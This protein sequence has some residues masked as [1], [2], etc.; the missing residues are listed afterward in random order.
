MANQGPAPKCPADAF[1]TD[2]QDIEAYDT[3]P[4][5]LSCGPT[6]NDAVGER[7]CKNKRGWRRVVRNFTP[8]WFS[9]NMGTGI[10]SILL[11]NLPYNATWLQYIAYIIFALNIFLFALFL[12]ISIMRYTLYPAIWTA[13]VRHPAQSL[14]LGTFPMGLATIINMT[15]FVC[16]P[17]W[18]GNWWKLAWA[19]WWFDA[20]VSL[21]TCFYLPFIMYVQTLLASL[22]TLLTSPTLTA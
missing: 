20:V 1:Q 22:R 4:Y 7:P 17:A 15:V 16:V 6:H 14:F 11:C 8:S 3:S 5:Q 21:A 18:G 9:V 19:L 10:S 2:S 13:M 12:C